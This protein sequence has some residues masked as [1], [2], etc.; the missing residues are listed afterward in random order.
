MRGNLSFRTG[1][2]AVGAEL[3]QAIAALPG[4]GDGRPDIDIRS[5]AVYVRVVTLADD[6]AALTK[7]DVELA[8]QITAAAQRLNL[9]ADPSA[10]LALKINFLLDWDRSSEDQ[11]RIVDFWRTILGYRQAGRW[12]LADES[13]IDLIDPAR[14][15]I[16]FGFEYVGANYYNNEGTRPDDDSMHLHIQ[17]PGEL[18]AARFEAVRGLGG[19]VDTVKFPVS[20]WDTN[21]VH[22]FVTP[23]DPR[24]S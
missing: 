24:D 2:L 4:T 7:R 22:F 19:D 21:G 13:S 1:S 8:Q 12:N 6:L 16:P 3:V 15:G 20:V 10:T 18:A 5:D 23:T 11:D 17:M 9:T 14:R